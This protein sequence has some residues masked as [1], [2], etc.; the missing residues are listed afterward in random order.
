MAGIQ[1]LFFMFAN[2]VVIPISV[3]HAFELSGQD[4]ASAMQQSFVWT[5]IA[6][7]L[8]ALVGHKYA[9]MEGQQGM[10][11]GFILSL[12]ASASSMDIPLSVLGGALATG[13]IL[14][15]VAVMLLGAAG[16]GGLLDK[17]FNPAV[18]FVFFILLSIQ[19]AMI[20]FKG[21]LGISEDG[22]IDLS[23][24][25]VSI[26]IVV[27]VLGLQVWGRAGV[28]NFSILIG[29][30]VGWAIYVVCLPLPS[31]VSA[32]TSL[33]FTWFPWGTPNMEISIVL[34][35]F[36]TGLINTTNVAAALKGAET[37]FAEQTSDSQYRRS[38]G[39]TGV[40]SVVS[41]VM[42]LVPYAPYA[43]SLG[44]LESTRITGRTPFL[45]GAILFVILG[46]VPALSSVLSTMPISV[47]HAVLFAAYLNL[48][49]AALRQLEGMVFSSQAVIRM[50][51]PVLIGISLMN[52]PP[53]AFG[54]LPALLRPLLGNG[55]LVG[56]LL[57]LL[58]ELIVMMKPNILRPN[59]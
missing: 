40:M 12:T 7:I 56:I 51:L 52:I 29:I 2:T 16:L 21:M 45:I 24:A 20:F 4:I 57:S 58:L 43:S 5:G 18:M 25:S 35:A 54:A 41:G 28:R 44:F 17:C 48:F 53:E 31:E 37:V 27:L 38:F 47:G 13:M 23:V 1:W 33:T 6:C 26:L 34:A 14:S 30:I 10:W 11:W 3:G 55:M 42:G 8:Q 19:L 50:S 36:I 49:G 59:V 22:S 9:I 46:L 39:V 32:V 15:G